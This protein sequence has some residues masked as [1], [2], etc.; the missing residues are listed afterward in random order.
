MY[1]KLQ[2]ECI[3]LTVPFYKL[4]KNVLRDIHLPVPFY[5]SMVDEIIS[6]L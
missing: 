2:E 5:S 4:F 1:N 3:H 6:F